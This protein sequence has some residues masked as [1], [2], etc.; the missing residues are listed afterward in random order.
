MSLGRNEKSVSEQWR[1]MLEEWKLQTVATHDA[2][3]EVESPPVY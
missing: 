3:E 2:T 1:E